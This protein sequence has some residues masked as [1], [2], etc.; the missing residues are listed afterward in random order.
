MIYNLE[1]MAF[2]AGIGTYYIFLTATSC[3]KNSTTL[4]LDQGGGIEISQDITYIYPGHGG[5]R[6]KVSPAY[7]CQ[8]LHARFIG[9]GFRHIIAC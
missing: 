8:S 7:R 1:W 4:P 5:P 6:E 2:L 3:W 9:D